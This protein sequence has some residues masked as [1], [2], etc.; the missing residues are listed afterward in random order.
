MRSEC[1][2]WRNARPVRAAAPRSR[3][4]S[5]ACPNGGWPRSWPSATAS[6]QVLVQPQRPRDRA[7]DADHL[8]GVG[9]PRAVVVAL[10]RDEDL[11]LV[12]EPAER[13]GVHDAVA[14]ALER[15]S[16]GSTA[17]PAAAARA[18]RRCA[19]P[20]APAPPPRPRAAAPRTAARPAPPRHHSSPRQGSEARG[21]AGPVSDD[22]GDGAAVD[23]PRRAQH[24]RRAGRA[25]EDHDVGDLA[26]LGH[27]ADGPP[28]RR[29]WP[30]PP[31]ACRRDARAVWSARPPSSSHA[32]VRDGPGQTALTSTPCFASRSATSRDSD[33]SAAFMTR[34]VG[35]AG[36]RALARR[37]R[38][39]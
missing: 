27:A 4:A 12:L 33:S 21:R 30:A 38:R 24:V 8:E 18:W 9:Q 3:A 16:A 10:G 29:P 7:R 19:P 32:G 1:W 20:A 25:Q 5:P 11:R 37:W 2:L 13:L 26:G 35:H 6:R 14:V 17:P 39:R 23:A 34:V 28:A 22:D 31:R 15:A 36:A